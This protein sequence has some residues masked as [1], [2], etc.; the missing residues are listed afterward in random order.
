MIPLTSLFLFLA[1][2]RDLAQ[3][4]LPAPHVQGPPKAAA[5]L[6]GGAA[7]PGLPPSP[8]QRRAEGLHLGL[9]LHD[10][11]EVRGGLREGPQ[12]RAE[13]LQGGRD[14]ARQGRGSL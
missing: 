7:R 8:A 4:P 11:Q 13:E 5:A 10:V 2:E 6:P 1:G 12:E 14:Q 9:K 3:V